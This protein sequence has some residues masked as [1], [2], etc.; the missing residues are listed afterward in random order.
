VFRTA[1]YDLGHERVGEFGTISMYF[2]FPNPDLS[3]INEGQAKPLHPNECRDDFRFAHVWHQIRHPL[4][5]IDSMA[6]SFTRKVRLWTAQTCEFD[7]PGEAGELRASLDDKIRWAM[8]Y[9]YH[10][11]LI[12]RNQAE[13]TFRLE[14]FPWDVMLRRLGLPAQPLPEV[15]TS[16]NRGLRYAFKASRRKQIDRD[17]YKLTWTR[18]YTLD[19]FYARRCMTLARQCGYPNIPPIKEFCE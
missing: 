11:N 10:N 17:M 19:P 8:R 15:S 1:G 3:L 5:A 7:L 9:W 4:R 18:L 16:I 13:L 12:C 14:D 2:P 6:G